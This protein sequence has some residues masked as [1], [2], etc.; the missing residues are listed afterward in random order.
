MVY[1]QFKSQVAPGPDTPAAR[2]V[3]ELVTPP[4]L[5]CAAF[6]GLLLGVET[7]GAQ[8][9]EVSNDVRAT[10]CVDARASCLIVFLFG[11][12]VS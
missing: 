11:M 3:L 12:F 8:P 10:A 2:V 6:V 9:P 4:M 7:L 5:A 1:R